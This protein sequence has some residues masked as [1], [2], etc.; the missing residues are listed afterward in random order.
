[1]S[2]SLDALG[3]LDQLH[4]RVA[5]LGDLD[6]DLALI[7]PA[8][9]EHL[10]QLLAR[11]VAPLLLGAGRPLGLGLATRRHHK[12]SGAFRL[13]RP[14][15]L[16]RLLHRLRPS[17]EQ[18]IEQALVRP[19]LR[20]GVDLIFPLGAHQI[21]RR[22][23]QVPHHGLGVPADVAHLGEL[24]G[25]DLDERG[26]GEPGQPAGHL[27]LSHPGGADHD[28]VVGGDLVPDVVRRLGPPPPVPHGDGNRLLGGLLAHD[29]A[30][31][32]GDDQPGWHLLQ[33]RHGRDRLGAW[34]GLNGKFGG[35]VGHSKEGKR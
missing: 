19:L 11:A 12:H 29:V 1:M 32:L 8:V 24:G 33:P 16:V 17:R 15:R 3:R 13:V 18:Q 21:D 2:V 10:A 5:L 31:E 30:V 4:H 23:D 22:V 34:G 25:L 9:G 20:L 6:L 26:T 7:E 35:G 27:R 28:D 14:F